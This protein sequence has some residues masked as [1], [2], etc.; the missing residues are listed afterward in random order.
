MQEIKLKE[1]CFPLF[2]CPVL[3]D[4]YSC[5]SAAIYCPPQLHQRTTCRAVLQIGPIQQINL[6]QAA[7]AAQPAQPIGQCTE[8]ARSSQQQGRRKL[9]KL[10][11]PGKLCFS[12]W[13]LREIRIDIPDV[14]HNCILRAGMPTEMNAEVQTEVLF[15]NIL[16]SGLLSLSRSY[17]HNGLSCSRDAF[18][19]QRSELLQTSLSG[20]GPALQ[21]N[22]PKS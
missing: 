19:T 20:S 13:E 1:F 9:C 8:V 12:T 11:L 21:L 4:T 14:C 3:P 7:T 15:Q 16:I 10:A 5:P 17:W 18:L 6:Q 22:H 2:L